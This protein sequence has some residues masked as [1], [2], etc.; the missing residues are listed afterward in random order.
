[1]PR[2][3]ASQLA[4]ATG[5]HWVSGE[6]ASVDGF[7]FDS[8]IVAPGEMFVALLTGKRDGHD[9]LEAALARGATAALVSRIQP[10]A[11]PQLV[12][13]DTL[14]AFQAIARA[15]RAAWPHPVVGITGSV[16][17]TSTKDILAHL[18]GR[19]DCAAT[20]GNFNNHIGVPMSI[21][22]A[23]PARHRAMVLEAGTNSPGEIAFL[24]DLIRPTVAIVTAVGPAHLDHLVN[25]AGVA[26]EKAALLQGEPA[27]SIFPAEV[28]S[29][30][31]F[32]NAPGQV[33][34]VFAGD[35][36]AEPG[37][38][39][40]QTTKLEAENN[41]DVPTRHPDSQVS[42]YS[43]LQTTSAPA[44]GLTIWLPAEVA[45]AEP[46]RA[47]FQSTSEGMARNAALA[48]A[49]ATYMGVPAAQIEERLA[50]WQPLADRG[51]WVQAEG[52]SYY[53]DCYN[54]N[55]KSFVD[56]FQAF[57]QRCPQAPRVFVLGAMFELGAERARWHRWVA[58]RCPAQPGDRIILVGE[59]TE[60]YLPG[61][62]AF[63]RA[64]V[65]V[66]HVSSAEAA[67]DLLKATDYPV[68]LKGGHAARLDILAPQPQEVSC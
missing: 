40:Y 3:T 23:D 33:W 65:M 44:V 68:Y 61:L 34:P 15:H 11:L 19:E 6:P 43:S 35:G 17:K 42:N 5:G 32:Q 31:P 51:G 60:A 49:A 53:V 36:P 25:L 20:P 37:R 26:V 64:G 8:R 18:L 58:E 4:A 66:T 9:F 2:F 41:E 50:T 27:L 39:V 38:V 57:H 16:G 54:A 24:A 48:V 1:M 28:I 21:L 22:R 56:S 30:E 12:V 46:L 7:H 14:A 10:V 63:Q 29:Y 13:P 45:S 62:S 55:P 47:P 67:R 59:G 52:R